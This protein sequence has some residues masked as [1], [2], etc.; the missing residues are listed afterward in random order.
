MDTLLSLI[1]EHAPHFTKAQRR[2]AEFVTGSYEDAAFMTAAALGARVGVSE[3]TVVRFAYMLELDG[4][5]EMQKLMREMLRHRLT[6][7]Q[8]IR[9]A[10]GISQQDALKTVLTAD[11]NNI[12]ATIDLIDNASFDGAIAAIL[13][14]RRVYVIGVRSAMV[15]AQFLAYYLNYVCDEVVFVNG[16]VQDVYE[17]VLRC[18]AEDVC[19]GVSFPRYSSRTKNAM[20]YAKSR[21]ATLVALTD[22]ADSPIARISDFVLLARSELASFADS[23]VAPL[24][25][26]NA[27][28]MMVGNARKDEAY[29]H[30]TQLEEIWSEEGVYLPMETQKEEPK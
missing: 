24:S 11:M 10:D 25:V 26:V 14:A 16:A 8:R 22:A 15:I 19:F 29:R 3:S 7:V 1:K 23:L 12:R 9:L 17:K 21:G 2:I 6:S 13:R 4:Y 20:Q 5:P 18:D 30:L 27:I 28:I